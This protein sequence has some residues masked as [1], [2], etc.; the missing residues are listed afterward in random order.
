RVPD[1]RRGRVGRPRGVRDRERGVLL[2]RGRDARGHRAPA[3][4]TEQP[5]P[6][7]GLLPA[8][9]DP[10]AARVPRAGTP[11]RKGHEAGP[12]ASAAAA[13]AMR[14][15][16]LFAVLVAS[17]YGAGALVAPLFH[18]TFGSLLGMPFQDSLSRSVL[19]CG[20]VAGLL[21]LRGT[22]SFDRAGLGWPPPGARMSARLPVAILAGLAVMAAVEGT[23]LFTGLR[24]FDI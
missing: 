3:V 2:P 13:T 17:V 14:H 7:A 21:Y 24:V 19:L 18:A 20:I 9:A 16:L 8:G 6:A 22:G 11:D 10:G 5:A 12:V 15:L 23:Q 1:P 4:H